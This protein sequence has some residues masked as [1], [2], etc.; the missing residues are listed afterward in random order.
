MTHAVY[1]NIAEWY[2]SYLSDNPIYQ[3]MVVPA[4]LELIGDA[5]DQTICDF[6]CGQGVI[7]RELARRGAHVTGVDLSDQL[8]DMAQRYEVAEPLGITYVQGDVQDTHLLA[9]VTFDGCVCN[10]ALM[11]I[12]DLAAAF[13]TMCRLVRTGG[14]LVFSLTHPC[15]EA[16]HAQWVTRDDGGMARA[17]SSYFR[18]GFWQSEGGGIRSRVG[19]YHRTLSTYLNTMLTAGFT[20]EYLLEPPAM[21]ERARQVVGNRE[22]PSL[23]LVRARRV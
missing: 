12:P 15:F 6:A 20:L 17:I 16:P 19:A 1:N 3:E 7:A 21:G 22:V 10:V 23:L 5:R 4:L 14:W 8:L 18:E 9:D 11:D 13:S 2:D